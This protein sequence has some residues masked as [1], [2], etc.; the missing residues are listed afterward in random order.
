MSNKQR[1]SAIEAGV[2]VLVALHSPPQNYWGIL[3][4]ITLAGVFLR[5]VDLDSFD[6]WVHALVHDEPFIGIGHLFFPM[7][8][9]ERIAKDEA[10]AG[11]PSLFEQ[12]V[13]RAGTK[14][15]EL[16]EIET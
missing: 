9:V 4:E 11:I 7:W 14:V 3:D 6:D 10:G 13:H 12:A 5:G 8:R 1:K 16:L 2:P 15:T